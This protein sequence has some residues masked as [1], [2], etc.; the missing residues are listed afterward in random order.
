MKAAFSARSGPPL[1]C[2]ACG[3]SLRLGQY[4]DDGRLDCSSCGRRH[5]VALAPALLRAASETERVGELAQDDEATCFYHPERRAVAACEASGRY[6]CELC[7]VEVNGHVYSM[8]AFQTLR[9]GGQDARFLVEETRYDRGALMLAL[10]PLLSVF[11]VGFTIF[12]GPMAMVLAIFAL[13]RR[14][15]GPVGRGPWVAIAALLLGLGQT[16][17]WIFL[18]T[19]DRT[20]VSALPEAGF[21][22]FG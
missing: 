19:R 15:K 9:A 18:F 11:L 4:T 2:A 12:T 3:A 14:V 22:R 17:F 8:E 20:P 1:P 7:R 6:L 10:L 5:E 21:F 16:A 13:T